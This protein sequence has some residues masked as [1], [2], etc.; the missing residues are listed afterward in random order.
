MNSV[1]Q[2]LDMVGEGQES[3]D[4]KAA[5]L[6]FS[7]R[8][9]LIVRMHE[10]ALR[11]R[12]SPRGGLSDRPSNHNRY[13]GSDDHGFPRISTEDLT[14]QYRGSQVPSSHVK[15]SEGLELYS[16]PGLIDLVEKGSP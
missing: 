13:R 2:K 5:S 1:F 16:L 6:F 14:Y 7:P 4:L 12:K 15:R 9:I 8:C 3:S 10:N 11:S